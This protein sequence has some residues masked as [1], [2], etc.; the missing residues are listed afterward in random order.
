MGRINDEKLGQMS[1]A[2]KDA[3]LTGDVL[4]AR[5]FE[6]LG[7]EVAQEY[8]TG[9][10][11][12]PIAAYVVAGEFLKAL[13]KNNFSL[14]SK[15]GGTMALLDNNPQ[16][17]A[18]GF[19]PSAGWSFYRKGEKRDGDWEVFNLDLRA[20]IGIDSRNRGFMVR[21]SVSGPHM[22]ASDFLPQMRIF[23]VVAEYDSSANR[24]VKT[25]AEANGQFVVGWHKM[26]LGGIRNLGTLFTEFSGSKDSIVRLANSSL[27]PFQPSAFVINGKTMY[28]PEPNQATLFDVWETQLLN[29]KLAL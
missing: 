1:E 21:P 13:R 17:P 27:S 9:W 5:V 23:S 14:E 24:V 28:L 12:K 18:P 16:E 2:V 6:H 8:G 29:Y 26:Q 11:S 25:I 20:W 3:L 7:T 10:L 22:S 15:D 4:A 19:A